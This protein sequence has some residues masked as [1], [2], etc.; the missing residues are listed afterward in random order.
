[1]AGYDE[2]MYV[3]SDHAGRMVASYDHNPDEVSSVNLIYHEVDYIREKEHEL[4]KEQDWGDFPEPIYGKVAFGVAL[5]DSRQLLK[6]LKEEITSITGT[7]ECI[8][9]RGGTPYLIIR[10]KDVSMK[11]AVLQAIEEICR[12]CVGFREFPVTCI[13]PGDVVNQAEIA[14]RLKRSNESIRLYSINERG[15]GDFPEPLSGRSNR[16]LVWSWAEVIW[17]ATHR[18]YINHPRIV[19]N[20]MDIKAINTALYM[21]RDVGSGMRETIR[22]MVK[23]LERLKEELGEL[24]YPYAKLK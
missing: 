13:E 4:R 11:D 22:P 21:R 9:I 1:M 10:R 6:Q 2:I 14:R 15:G 20:S 19:D 17:W 3:L 12:I 23:T 18:I 8:R 16:P 5:Y 7:D 24:R